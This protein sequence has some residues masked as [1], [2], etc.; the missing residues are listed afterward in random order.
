MESTHLCLLR[1]RTQL[2]RVVVGG[3]SAQGILSDASMSLKSFPCDAM[4]KSS[5]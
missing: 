3:H 2:V 5:A 4:H 1:V